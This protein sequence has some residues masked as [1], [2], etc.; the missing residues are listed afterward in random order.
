MNVRAEPESS[1]GMNRLLITMLWIVSMLGT[2]ALLLQRYRGGVADKS[3]DLTTYF[4]PAAQQILAGS[5][6]YVVPG[7]VYSPLVAMLITPVANWDYLLP[8]WVVL[9][10]AC[11]VA[12]IALMTAALRR[13]HWG[14]QTPVLFGTG[15]L[16]LLSNWPTT[17]VFALGQTDFM[18]MAAFALAGWGSARQ[19][20]SAAGGGIAL[21]G[22]IKTWPGLVAM[23]FFRREAS[24]RLPTVLWALA[25]VVAG[26]GSSLARFGLDGVVG[27]AAAVVDAHR[28]PDL[29]L[30]SAMGFG[31]HLF[32]STPGT[33]ALIHSPAAAWAASIAYGLVVL[34]LLALVLLRPGEPILAL[35]HTMLAC[36]LILPV[37]HATYLIYGVPL[38]WIWTARALNGG[39]RRPALVAG[40]VG[41]FTWWLVVFRTTWGDMTT[42]MSTIGYAIV[43]LATLCVLA[44]SV[45]AEASSVK[46][47]AS[48]AVA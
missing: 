28:Q 32:G 48:R 13:Q 45:L 11:A 42:G 1:P 34:T 5:S 46:P 26:V 33:I 25:I 16:T 43:M 36:V 15:A 37:S 19:R 40:L 12:C 4:Q 14:W 27:W 2:A 21:A 22:L 35:W 10:L 6:P 44:G 38:L 29:I 41:L 23:W 9:N 8:A 39:W 7:Y 17:I 3:I 20:P 31:D 30:F 18:V 47:S 24:Q